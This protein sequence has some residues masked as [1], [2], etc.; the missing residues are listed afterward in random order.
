MIDATFDSIP[1]EISSDDRFNWFYM[2]LENS[3]S[4]LQLCSAGG[5]INVTRE[6]FNDE[7][8][9]LNADS[10]I[11]RNIPSFSS[12]C[13]DNSDY[14]HRFN[15]LLRLRFRIS[16]VGVRNSEISVLRQV[17]R[18]AH[19]PMYGILSQNDFGLM[20]LAFR[21]A[22]QGETILLTDDLSIQ[23]ALDVICRNRYV[24]LSSQTIDTQ[25]LWATHSLSYLEHPYSCCEVTSIEYL[26]LLKIIHD[27]MELLKESFNPRLRDYARL[28]SPIE[29]NVS[30][31]NK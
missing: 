7:M 11:R 23:S 19:T 28:V 27:F 1:E 25:M 17:L 24:T 18:S 13:D 21:L 31:F 9:P 26:S 3:L 16:S 29:R 6:M 2:E 4:K 30:R 8:D 5:I 15:R 12:I 22:S 20:V 14:Y 10:T